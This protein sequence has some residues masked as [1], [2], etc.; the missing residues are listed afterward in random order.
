MN[1]TN[2]SEKRIVGA[3][4]TTTAPVE[5]GVVGSVE[6]CRIGDA[7]KLFGL[8][9][10]YCYLLIQQG[11]IRSV[12]LRKRGAKTGVRLLDADSVRA[13]LRA[14]VDNGGAKR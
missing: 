12:C 3:N 10:T 6:F 13:Y 9:R 7:R 14:N 11:K 4:T 1:A 8:G 5:P 2:H